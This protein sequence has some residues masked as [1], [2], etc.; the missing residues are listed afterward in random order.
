N[1]T[2]PALMPETPGSESASTSQRPLRAVL[3]GGF[4][5]GVGDEPLAA[6]GRPRIQSLLAYLLLHC[7]T[8]QSRQHL[9]F[10]MWP[11]STETQARANLRNLVHG[12]LHGL[13]DVEKRL[14]M[15]SGALGWRPDATVVVDVAEFEAAVKAA[16]AARRSADTTAAQAWLEAAVSIYRGELL[17]GLF[18]DWIV[19][20]RDRLD[21]LAR[22]ALESL[23]DLLEAQRDYARAIAH[24]ERLLQQD[25]LNETTYRR[26]MRL[27]VLAGD[28]AGARRVYQACVE[29]LRRELGEEPEG[30]TREAYAVAQRDLEEPRPAGDQPSR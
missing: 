21:G 22:H 10:M 12:L 14:E 23:V 26:L 9:A 8:P 28:H 20:E 24:A 16:D 15:G 6:F 4:A 18:D 17:P 29:V 11:D 19:A 25:R 3:L 5:I 7:Q 1:R 30:A 27:H 2:A 13:P